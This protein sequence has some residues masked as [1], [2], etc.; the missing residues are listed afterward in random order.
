[1][2]MNSLVALVGCFLAAPADL[3]VVKVTADDTVISQSCR[4]EIPA[5][6]VIEDRNGDGVIQIAKSGLII[7]FVPGTVLRGAAAD[8]GPDKY[9]GIG[10]RLNGH[11]NVTIRNARISGFLSGLWATR[12]DRLTLDGVDASDNRRAHLLSTPVAEDG[13]DWLFP[14]NNED[15]GWLTQYGAA[16]YVE[17]SR[18]VTV[19][20]CRV[21]HGQNALLLDRVSDSKIYDNDFSFNSG[22]GI[23]LWRCNQN[24]ISRNAIDFCVRGYSHGVYNRGQDSA[25]I[26]TFEQNNQNVIAENSITHGGDG[27]FGFAGREA[28]GETGQ[29]DPQWYKR[30][31]NNDN[32]LIRNDFSYAPAHGIEMTFS[33][34]NKF[35]GNRFVG[36]AICGIWGGYSQETFIADN[37]FQDNGE[38]GYGLERGGVNIEHGRGNRIV[39]NRF[40]GNK[41]GVHLWWG[42]NPDFEKKTWGLANDPQSVDNL[43]A[44]NEFVTDRLA[45][46][47]RGH[48]EV[49]LGQN[50]FCG[51]ADQI[52]TE[53]DVKVVQEDKL[54]VPPMVIPDHQVFGKNQP[55]GA[56]PALRGRENIVMTEWGPWDHESPL[57]RIAPA[58]VSRSETV[59]EIYQMPAPVQIKLEGVGVAGTLSSVSGPRQTY[60]IR[61]DGSGFHP[62]TLN[63]TSG[64]F[65]QQLRGSILDTKWSATFFKWTPQTDP[66]QELA[67][68]RKLAT[69][70]TAVTT[71]LGGLSLK[72]GMRGPSDLNLS[73]TVNAAKLGGDHFGL[74][75]TTRLPLP[76]G[77]W[78]MKTLSDDGVRVT[79]D[80]RSVIDNW[81]WHGATADK[82][83]LE[84]AE[85]KTVEIVVEYFEIDGAAVLEF[86]LAPAR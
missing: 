28:I 32:L 66:R 44:G 63:L 79:A 17:D 27:F 78:E 48:S 55:V 38:M 24:V 30:R 85:D 12:A 13:A 80:G 29:H 10:I 84:V 3:P 47:F 31:G 25:G 45:F 43:I 50:V 60:T 35:V 41:C 72:Y 68:W 22:W 67:G 83:T 75:A 57:V 86:E 2:A 15:R 49:T 19:H 59:Y 54:A 36:N 16:I 70:P 21:R 52:K 37:L 73:P 1:M 26:L 56:R 53:G 11:E 81:T 58:A 9:K 61:A 51:V 64:D 39:Q 71:E 14:H 65:K 69:G 76:K 7:E 20:D 42:P 82:G 4:I 46:H 34:G 5:G 6:T 18:Q 33:F 74:I 62:Y 23:G 77:A 40:M 8:T